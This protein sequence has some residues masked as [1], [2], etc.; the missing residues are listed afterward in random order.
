M[1]VTYKAFTTNRFFGVEAEFNDL[2]IKQND[3]ATVIR[4]FDPFND[5][6]VSGYELSDGSCWHV[7]TDS[8]CGW[9][10]ASYKGSG[11]YDLRNIARCIEAV[12]NEGG[13]VD[14]NCG[15]HIHCDVSDFSEEEVAKSVAYW[16]KI[17]SILLNSVPSH[18]VSNRFCKSLRRMYPM[19][20]FKIFPAAKDFYEE[21]KP[22]EFKN[23]Q[24]RVTYNI[25][26]YVK[27][28]E[29]E[30]F[31]RKTVELRLPEATVKGVDVKNW[32]RLFV[33]FVENVRNMPMPGSCSMSN[34]VEAMCILGLHQVSGALILSKA[35]FSTKEWFLHRVLAHS[36]SKKLC[37]G[38]INMLN[39]MW[40]P[41]RKYHLDKKCE[42]LTEQGRVYA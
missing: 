37:R 6:D 1:N 36:R 18:R 21:I 9:E 33:T 27:S 38:A 29:D 34:I 25:C 39:N 24:R 3:I 10:V 15:L 20:K 30:D 40:F 13:K 4:D 31:N 35:L 28:L 42:V 16:M 32:V 17:E 5:V 7:K 23:R 12:G 22:Y 14:E 8:T 41:L 26:N 11:V 19:R 2:G